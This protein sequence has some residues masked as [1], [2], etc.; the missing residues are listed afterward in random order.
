MPP[1]VWAAWFWK[2]CTV[3]L[4]VCRICCAIHCKLWCCNVGL[5]YCR[6][7]DVL[8]YVLRYL[9]YRI[10]LLSFVGFKTAG[11]VTSMF[12]KCYTVGLPVWGICYRIHWQVWS[13]K[14]GLSSCRND[15]VLF[16]FLRYVRY[17]NFGLSDC[18]VNGFNSMV[19]HI[20][21]LI[22]DIYGIVSSYCR[23]VGII[24]CC[25]TPLMRCWNVGG[26]SGCCCVVWNLRNFNK[27][28]HSG[29]VD[30]SLFLC[31]KSSL[32]ACVGIIPNMGV[33]GH[34]IFSCVGRICYLRQNFRHPVPHGM[35]HKITRKRDVFIIFTYSSNAR[36]AFKITWNVY[37]KFQAMYPMQCIQGPTYVLI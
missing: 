26:L 14:V 21:F 16:V 15:D 34:S 17:R 18:C 6:N 20:R 27:L 11:C 29:F 8:F 2:C 28:L 30:L 19:W 5:S 4:L 36:K 12:W 37:T 25:S 10:F 35:N 23:L 32:C 24:I 33:W 1:V 7:Y 13:C 3:G 22:I 31:T 9:R